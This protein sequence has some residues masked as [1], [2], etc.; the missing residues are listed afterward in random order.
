MVQI[1]D[2]RD[3]IDVILKKKILFLKIH[4]DY[5]HTKFYVFF[6]IF[7]LKDQITEIQII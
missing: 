7:E 3:W 2:V 6:V 1:F 5:L 4:L